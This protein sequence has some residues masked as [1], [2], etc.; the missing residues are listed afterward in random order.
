MV[1]LRRRQPGSEVLRRFEKIARLLTGDEGAGAD[2]GIAWVHQLCA[3]L[4]I[5]PLRAYGIGES[6]VSALCEKAASAS[7]MRGNPLSLTSGEL[8]EILLAAL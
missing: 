3:D 6:D 4:R 1:Y 8:R 7:S 5:P 2:E